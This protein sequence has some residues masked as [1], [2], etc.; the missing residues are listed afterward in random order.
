MFAADLRRAGWQLRRT[1]RADLNNSSPTSSYPVHCVA[2][3]LSVRQMHS[4]S[5]RYRYALLNVEPW[6]FWLLRSRST[7]AK[8]PAIRDSK[9]SAGYI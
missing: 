1:L 9:N 4:A 7:A 3:F 2:L 8:L 6:V 5:L